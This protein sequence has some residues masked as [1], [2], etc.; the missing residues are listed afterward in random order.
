MPPL[1]E[2]IE[3][4]NYRIARL[5]EYLSADEEGTISAAGGE[6]SR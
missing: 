2:A 4:D 1:F 3:L 6:H 5:L